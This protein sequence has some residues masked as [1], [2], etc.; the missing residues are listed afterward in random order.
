VFCTVWLAGII[1]IDTKSR[2]AVVFPVTVK[3]PVAITVLP[4][5]EVAL[6]VIVVVPGPTAVAKPEELMVPTWALLDCQVAVEVRLWVSG[7]RL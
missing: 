3:F 7:A 6:A 1:V 4:L 5:G 2:A